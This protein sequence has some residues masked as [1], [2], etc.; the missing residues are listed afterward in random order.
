[1]SRWSQLFET[2]VAGGRALL[3]VE[4]GSVLR[5]IGGE[6]AVIVGV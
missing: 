3:G 4:A 1:M 2:V 6:R 5:F